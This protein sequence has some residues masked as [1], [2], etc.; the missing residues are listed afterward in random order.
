MAAR[1]EKQARN[2]KAKRSLPAAE[3][4]APVGDFLPPG[5]SAE[6]KAEEIDGEI[7]TYFLHTEKRGLSKYLTTALKHYHRGFR[8][9]LVTKA[10]LI[11]DQPSARVAGRLAG[12][13]Y[14]TAVLWA[15][16][17]ILE[18]LHHRYVLTG[19]GS[20]R[21]RERTMTRYFSV[22][23]KVEQIEEKLSEAD[24]LLDQASIDMVLRFGTKF[25]LQEEG[26]T[27]D[28]CYGPGDKVYWRSRSGK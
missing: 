6:L 13:H 7:T 10:P 22:K 24:K 20:M 8:A 15:K 14:E 18:E 26:V 4:P 21:D 9:V 17:S 27:L 23:E 1:R 11:F 25:V 28:A 3:A 5:F 12:D 16:R 19:G 2:G